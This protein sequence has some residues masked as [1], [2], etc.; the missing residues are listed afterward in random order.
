[1][2]KYKRT[3][4]IETDLK[5]HLVESFEGHVSN[6]DHM[7]ENFEKYRTRLI[8]VRQEKEKARLELI[9]KILHLFVL[10]TC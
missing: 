2:H 10:L 1:M 7:K 5:S 3:D 4:F 6:L 9:G 8:V